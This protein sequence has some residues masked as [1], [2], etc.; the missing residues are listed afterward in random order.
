[1]QWV[2]W[3]SFKEVC[4]VFSIEFYSHLTHWS[5]VCTVRWTATGDEKEHIFIGCYKSMQNVVFQ[6]PF[7]DFAAVL[8]VDYLSDHPGPVNQGLLWRNK[9]G[10]Q[11]FA[12]LLYSCTDIP[13]HLVMSFH[14]CQ[15]GRAKISISASCG[16]KYCVGVTQVDEVHLE[17]TS[18]RDRRQT[19]AFK[20]LFNR[21]AV[22]ELVALTRNQQF[23]KAIP[24]DLMIE[25]EMR[26]IRQR[27]SGTYRRTCYHMMQRS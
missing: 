9:H 23:T 26:F 12:K 2:L 1:M 5:Y 14:C 18:R 20:F 3:K 7:K 16:H 8:D 6:L 24:D 21:M 13:Q 25:G 11:E 4:I 27:K 22:A 17:T 15:A 19:A 10:C